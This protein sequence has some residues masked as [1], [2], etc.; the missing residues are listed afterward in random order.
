MTRHPAIAKLSLDFAP[1]RL[2]L[3]QVDRILTHTLDRNERAY[4]DGNGSPAIYGTRTE[5]LVNGGMYF[6]SG[7]YTQPVGGTFHAASGTQ[8]ET[9]ACRFFLAD[10]IQFRRPITMTI[11][12][13]LL[14]PA[15]GDHRT[16][17]I[18]CL[19]DHGFGVGKAAEDTA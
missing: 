14:D 1:M 11:Q 3:L 5:D 18:D 2:E 12:H 6:D 8:D 4:T 7:P 9:A 17:L 13:G 16:N 10:A 15:F 19:S